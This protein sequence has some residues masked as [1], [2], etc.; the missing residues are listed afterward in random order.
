[1]VKSSSEQHY[2]FHLMEVPYV[3]ESIILVLHDCLSKRENLTD[4]SVLFRIIFRF[5]EK[6]VDI[7][8]CPD[9]ITW[10]VINEYV[11]KINID[12]LISKIKEEA[13]E[14]KKIGV[15]SEADVCIALADLNDGYHC[16]IK[17]PMQRKLGDGSLEDQQTACAVCMRVKGLITENE[18]MR[19][20]LNN[21]IVI[22]IPNCINGGILKG[23]GDKLYCPL[24]GAVR[25]V[26]YCKTKR[27]G[28]NCQWLRWSHMKIKGRTP[29]LKK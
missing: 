3:L 9:P 16:M 7:N 22:T 6:N 4:A 1:M 11:D 24:F 29:A 5:I 17:P 2:R 13:D 8:S 28:A 10:D 14:I 26:N 21:D 12:D 27:N 18:M 23:D 15:E 25:D 19:K 20:Q